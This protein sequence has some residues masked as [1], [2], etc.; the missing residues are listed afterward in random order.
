MQGLDILNGT[1]LP[2]ILGATLKKG[3]DNWTKNLLQMGQAVV[4]AWSF[5]F[6]K[7]VFAKKKDEAVSSDEAVRD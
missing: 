7:K 2:V 6:F 5:K 3:K 1:I 4:I